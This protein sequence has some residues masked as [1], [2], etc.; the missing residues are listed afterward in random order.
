MQSFRGRITVDDSIAA[1]LKS[2]GIESPDDGV[3]GGLITGDRYLAGESDPL[4]VVTP[5]DGSQLA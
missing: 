5:I 4:S 1:S 3:F 2:L